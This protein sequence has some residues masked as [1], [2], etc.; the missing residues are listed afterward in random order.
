MLRKRTGFVEPWVFAM[1]L[2]VVSI[3]WNIALTAVFTDQRSLKQEEIFELRRTANAAQQIAAE[4]KKV[5][6]R[7]RIP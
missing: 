3:L 1:I 5:G 4:A 7:W 6:S 2:S